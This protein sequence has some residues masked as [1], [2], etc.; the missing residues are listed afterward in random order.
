MHMPL[1]L[2]HNL[3]GD[4]ECNLG[5][6]EISPHAVAR[7]AAQY[8]PQAHHL[9]EEAARRTPLQ[10]LSASGWQ[11][12]ILV[13]RLLERH[14]AQRSLLIAKL[15]V[16][17]IR[18]LQP[19]RPGEVISV[20]LLWGRGCRSPA[21]SRNGGRSASIVATKGSGALAVRINCSILLG[22]GAG[23]A[24]LAFDC[25]DWYRRMSRVERR[26]G[27]HLVR[28]FEDVELGDEIALGSCRFTAG[29]IET[30]N[31]IVGGSGDRA[32]P[33]LAKARPDAVHGWHVIAMWTRMIV[34]YYHAEAEWLNQNQLA[35]PNLGPA[36]GVRDLTWHAPVHK[37]D[38]V[39]FKSWV[40]HKVGAGTSREW[41]MLVVGVEGTNQHGKTAVS[42]YPQLLLQKRPG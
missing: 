7:F 23:P 14:F 34:D 13:M 16:D 10:G 19:V 40:E 17:E 36:V 21:C 8:D 27:G 35:V 33:G 28:Y 9:D 24:N 31:H 11:T 12:C 42:F 22:D 1:D 25:A 38:R 39:T 32:D 15:V 6:L 29:G 20:R 4:D 2:T 26:T 30:Y 3:V 41:G 5:T 37:G 18:W